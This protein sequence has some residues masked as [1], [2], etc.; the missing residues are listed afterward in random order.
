MPIKKPDETK[1]E[2][3][4]RRAIKH[5]REE[6]TKA[7][8]KDRHVIKLEGMTI[9]QRAER[10]AKKDVKRQMVIIRANKAKN[11]S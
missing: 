5:G 8:R 3:K 6:E 9:M 4:E 1:K 10:Q 2:R 7:E 11:I